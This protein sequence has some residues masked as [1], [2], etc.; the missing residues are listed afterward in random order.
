MFGIGVLVALGRRL[1]AATLADTGLLPAGFYR[2][3]ALAA[4]EEENFPGALKWLPFAKDPV[5]TQLLVLRLR[6][7]AAKHEEQ[8]LAVLALLDQDP[9][10]SLRER[11]RALL[12]Q[13]SRATEL[14]RNYEREALKILRD[15][16]EVSYR[17]PYEPPYEPSETKHRPD[18]PGKPP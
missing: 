5:L 4:L 13:E 10:E 2:H 15:G 6:L 7:L 3:L 8:R 16:R 14:L 17:S 1:A 9:P 18:D 12:D 11:G